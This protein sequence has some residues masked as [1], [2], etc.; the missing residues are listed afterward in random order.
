MAVT[1][2]DYFYITFS[3]KK[4]LTMRLIRVRSIPV[5][6][7]THTHAHI[8]ARTT[9]KAPPER[10]ANAR[11]RLPLIMRFDSIVCLCDVLITQ[12]FGLWNLDETCFSG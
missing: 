6:Y 3:D 9:Q 4:L 12:V 10:S 1:N 2:L 7:N 11:T 8:F 5:E